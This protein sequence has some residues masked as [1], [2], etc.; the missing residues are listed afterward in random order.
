M[1]THTPH[2]RIGRNARS[3]WR[4]TAARSCCSWSALAFA[5]GVFGC[6]AARKPEL[7]NVLP[8]AVAS[9]QHIGRLPA[10]ATPA[11]WVLLT[12]NLIGHLEL[13]DGSALHYG[14][15]GERWLKRPGEP[16]QSADTFLPEDLVGGAVDPAG[17]VL[18]VG[19]KG[20]LYH[21]ATPLGAVDRTEH[22][23]SIRSL[24]SGKGAV[25]GIRDNALTRSID[26]G[27]TWS[28]PS[29]ASARGILK[30]V[31]LD[32]AGRGLAIVVPQQLLATADDGATW[33][34]IPGPSTAFRSLRRAPDAT[35]IYAKVDLASL[36]RVALEDLGALA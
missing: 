18:L 17:G 21:A 13:S 14:F 27:R 8:A 16:P 12:S 23:S 1:P 15:A 22:D 20:A 25:L 31:E 4:S 30:Q 19:H 2:L 29:V 26:G 11:R 34:S 6:G 5:W 33:Q 35:G 10:V 36:R 9:A 28:A 24:A 7:A 32:S 3:A